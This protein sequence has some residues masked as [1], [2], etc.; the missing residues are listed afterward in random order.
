M[1]MD[2]DIELPLPFRDENIEVPYTAE[3][4]VPTVRRLRDALAIDLASSYGTPQQRLG[5]AWTRI[6]ELRLPRK[7]VPNSV[8]N[9]IE[10]LMLAWDRFAPDGIK[11]YARTL[12]DE[13]VDREAGRIAWMLRETEAA[14]NRGYTNEVVTTE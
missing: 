4:L 8:L 12:S 10:E 5:A 1:D 3:Q 14:A 6:A 13:E 7:A 9:T 2:M 11:R